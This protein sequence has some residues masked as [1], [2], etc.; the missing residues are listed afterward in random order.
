MKSSILGYPID[1]EDPS[2]SVARV[3]DWLRKGKLRKYMACANPHSLVTA[4]KD[5]YFRCALL[6]ADILLPDGYGIILAARILGVPPRQRFSG[7]EFFN[8]LNRNAN[9]TGGLKYFFLGS[10]DYV[11]DL[12][13]KRFKREFP[14]IHVCGV[15]SPPFK[16]EFD[17]QDNRTMIDI[18]NAA[19]PDVLWVGMTAPKQEKWIWQNKDALRVPFIGAVGAVFD[20]YAGTVRRPPGFWQK[21]GLEWLVRFLGEPRRLWRR[22]IISMPIFLYWVLREKLSG[23]THMNAFPP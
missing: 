15:Y 12:L 10:T 19:Q 17:T 7:S 6:N 5:E 18:I 4:W 9:K 21:L 1:A 2:Q 14:D 13:T 20:F 3:L 22:N 8:A 23:K 16:E 11:L